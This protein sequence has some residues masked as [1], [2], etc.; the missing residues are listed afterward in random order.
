M[1][2]GKTKILIVDDD[3]DTRTMYAEVFRKERFEVEEAVDGADGF[4]KAVANAPH[5]V[6]TG[7]VMPGM[8]GF[9]LMEA[10]RNREVTRNV[11]VVISSHMGRQED[12]EKAERLGAGDFIARDLNTPNQ[13]VERI[14]AVL[15]LESYK[16]TFNPESLDARKLAREMHF[17]EKFKCEQCEGNLILTLRLSDVNK[18]EFTAKFMCPNC[19]RVQA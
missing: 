1:E 2:E 10:L 6:F 11:P 12:Q 15:N 18:R 3:E 13:V 4:E 7:I 9:A 19:G 8:D 16:L 14:R 5:I 17:N